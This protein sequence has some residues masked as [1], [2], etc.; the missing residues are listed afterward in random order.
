[1]LLLL[2]DPSKVHK[3]CLLTLCKMLPLLLHN[4]LPFRVFHVRELVLELRGSLPFENSIGRHLLSLSLQVDVSSGINSINL[5]VNL[6][7]SLFV[8]R[9]F[10]PVV[11]VQFLSLSLVESLD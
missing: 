2:L 8:T 5:L 11:L 6:L 4:H 3:G 9:I 1:M 10:L 7:N